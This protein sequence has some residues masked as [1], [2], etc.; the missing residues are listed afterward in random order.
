MA[1]AQHSVVGYELLFDLL[2][3]YVAYRVIGRLRPAGMVMVF[4]L[5][6][7]ALWRFGIQFLRVDPVK[8]G[9]LQEA[10]LITLILLAFLVPIF[11]IKAK[12][13]NTPQTPQVAAPPGKAQRK[14]KQ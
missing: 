7:Y 6:A 2:L 4:Y 11:V 14:S 13:E 12:W 9:G 8:V 3:A 1:F 10:H 5:T